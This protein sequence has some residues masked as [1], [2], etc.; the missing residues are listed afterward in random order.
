MPA[1][2]SYVAKPPPNAPP[3]LN[4][5]SLLETVIQAGRIPFTTAGGLAMKIRLEA[6]AGIARRAR[7]WGRSRT[8]GWTRGPGWR[9]NSAEVQ[10]HRAVQRV[11]GWISELANPKGDRAGEV[12]RVVRVG[13]AVDAERA[14][15]Q[16]DR[17]VG[18][19]AILHELGAGVVDD[20]HAAAD[21]RSP[22]IWE[23]AAQVEKVR[24]AA[25]E[26]DRPLQIVGRIELP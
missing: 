16:R 18:L 3:R 9:S 4:R 8:P 2:V 15:G 13:P 21:R 23:K 1:P 5:P 19:H 17:H 12:I 14:A 22:L 20:Q 6:V 25:G 11:S 26:G 24:P 10:G 7:R